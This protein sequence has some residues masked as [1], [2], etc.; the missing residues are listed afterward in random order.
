MFLD[1]FC[2]GPACDAFAEQHAHG[3]GVRRG[4]DAQHEVALVVR[5]RVAVPPVV[6]P[7]GE[8]TAGTPD[9]CHAVV[10]RG[11]VC[12]FEFELAASSVRDDGVVGERWGAVLG[13]AR[14]GD[15]GLRR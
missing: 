9:Q 12:W 13:G 2:G 11:E 10:Q 15:A 3:A 5:P 7:R 1:N 8:Q 4:L 6:R 14:L